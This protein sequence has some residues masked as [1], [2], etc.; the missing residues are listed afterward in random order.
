MK[1][2]NSDILKTLNLRCLKEDG[3]S[4]RSSTR[5]QS[6][7]KSWEGELGE[8]F[9]VFLAHIRT[10]LV[11][12]KARMN[13]LQEFEENITNRNALTPLPGYRSESF[14]C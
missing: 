5:R 8:D 6:S 7:G 12:E 3:A 4:E 11:K 13:L 10:I 2:R 14:H 1:L 9:D